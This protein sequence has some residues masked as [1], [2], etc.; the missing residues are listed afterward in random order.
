MLYFQSSHLH[1]SVLHSYAEVY[2]K[3]LTA[4]IP[5]EFGYQR[6]FSNKDNIHQ[7][8]WQVFTGAVFH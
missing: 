8:S 3:K 4:E 1:L 5:T 7:Q 6:G 2:M